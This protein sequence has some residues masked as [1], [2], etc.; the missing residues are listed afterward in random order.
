[1]RN[2]LIALAFSAVLPGAADNDISISGF[3]SA[4]AIYEDSLQSMGLIDAKT[5][6]QASSIP[7]TRCSLVWDALPYCACRTA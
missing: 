7:Q 5:T 2:T 1:M 4:E 3:N 6:F